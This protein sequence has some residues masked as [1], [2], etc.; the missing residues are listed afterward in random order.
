MDGVSE[1]RN[2]I[3]RELLAVR[4]ELAGVGLA[5]Y[6]QVLALEVRVPR[7]LQAAERAPL[8]RLTTTRTFIAVRG[9]RDTR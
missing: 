6:A 3:V 1:S 7:C 8:P 5:F 2:S 4:D 9:A